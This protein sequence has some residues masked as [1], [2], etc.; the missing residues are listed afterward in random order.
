VDL[1]RFVIYGLAVFRLSHLLAWEDGPFD[2]FSRLRGWLDIRWGLGKFITCQYC[3][4]VWFALG[5]WLLSFT[6]RMGDSIALIF[7]L[8]GVTLLIGER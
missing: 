2:M 3:L 7:A 4:S 1:L 8:S 5:F 6:G